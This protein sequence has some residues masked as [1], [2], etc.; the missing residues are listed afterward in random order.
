MNFDA[1]QVTVNDLLSVK[2]KYLIPRNQREFSWEKLQIEEF[3]DDVTRN[4]NYNNEHGRFEFN[5]YF[6]G[7]IVLSGQE[8]S[9]VLD[10]IDGQQRLTIIT[11]TLSLASRILKEIGYEKAGESVFNT[12]IV[13]PPTSILQKEEPTAKIEKSNG[14]DF[15]RLK[16]QADKDYN[17]NIQYEEDEKLDKAGKL[18]LD[19]L[20]KKNACQLLN[21]SRVG[22]KYSNLEYA[23]C[24][25][26]IIKMLTD[27]LKMVRILVGTS[28]D[29]YDIFEVLNAR[30]ISLSSIDLIKNKILQHCTQ[31]YPADF[32]KQKWAD[33]DD[34]LVENVSNPSI[35]DFVRTWWL[36]KYGYVGKDQLYRSFKKLISDDS[37]SVKPQ[38]FLN[39]LHAE[40]DSYI[41]IVAPK[42]E[43]WKQQDQK[44]IYESLKALD[45]FDITVAR[46]FIM[47]AIRLRKNKPRALTQTQFIDIL[48]SIER[49]HFRFNAICKARP[50]GIDLMYSGFAV[51][52]SKCTN[53][54]EVKTLLTEISNTINEK[55]PSESEFLGKFTQN[56]WYTNSK[57]T[58]KKLINYVFERLEISKRG[59][60]E[61]KHGLVSLEHIGSQ[62]NFDEKHVGKIGNL[63]PLCFNLNEDCKNYPFP[64]KLEKYKESE[65]INVQ[66]FIQ[67]YN[68]AE[69]T[70]DN[71]DQRSEQLAI[72]AYNLI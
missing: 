60:R 47:A 11:I 63:I 45:I 57:S 48:R 25:E 28:E 41:K 26:S 6:L 38:D 30:G 22:V 10:I 16:F 12:Y 40:I 36:S 39:E 68:G 55:M 71:V 4:I 8:T 70:K 44:T 72:E 19:K 23:N 24:L 18:I 17:P 2:R 49:F 50:S 67:L 13:A 62:S 66:E 9:G 3:W 27:Y 59:T 42:D 5:E 1:V 51:K 15:F 34:K 31:T 21:K 56:L 33:I 32:A 35:T 43:D 7:T 46:P 29:A 37:L 69:W 65:L 20:K 61:L 52:L 64:Q 53:A 58:Q 54:R 14:K